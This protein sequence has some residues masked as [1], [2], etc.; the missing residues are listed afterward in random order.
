MKFNPA[1][2]E[3]IC[4]LNPKCSGIRSTA[5]ASGHPLPMYK[6]PI[7]HLTAETRADPCQQCGIYSYVANFLTLCLATCLFQTKLPLNYP[8][9]LLENGKW[10][11]DN[12]SSEKN[13]IT[14]HSTNVDSIWR[15]GPQSH[16]E[17]LQHPAPWAVEDTQGLVKCTWR[18]PGRAANTAWLFLGTPI[19]AWGAQGAWAAMP[20][21]G[22]CE[23][24]LMPSV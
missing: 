13:P 2:T 1:W 14:S 21:P 22:C 11:A 4:N 9:P 19:L 7:N 3:P 12:T 18:E 6:S 24:A 16:R 17:K 10:N 8:S 5:Q 23:R 20:A 15:V